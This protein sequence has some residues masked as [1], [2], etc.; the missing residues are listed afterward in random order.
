[1]R[2][3]VGNEQFEWIL[4]VRWQLNDQQSPRLQLASDRFEKFSRR[5]DVFEDVD[6]RADVE[7]AWQI[8][9]VTREKF[10]EARD[11]F[12]AGTVLLVKLGAAQAPVGV[13]PAEAAKEPAVSTTDIDGGALLGN[14]GNIHEPVEELIGT[15]SGSAGR[16]IEDALLG[17]AAL[18]I[19]GVRLVDL[20]ALGLPLRIDYGLHSSALV[21]YSQ[22][23]TGAP[24]PAIR[25]NSPQLRKLRNQ[26]HTSFSTNMTACFHLK[27]E[28]NSRMVSAA[29]GGFSVAAS[30]GRMGRGPKRGA[31]VGGR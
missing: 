15:R 31:G 9:H 21:T 13:P 17:A 4:A 29:G 20:A 18:S 2:G 27:L 25:S 19:D 10:L 24:R 28:S 16:G 30:C 14:V 5:L 8:A 12:D 11:V 1:M 26:L 22:P 7:F 23:T 6:E 3:V